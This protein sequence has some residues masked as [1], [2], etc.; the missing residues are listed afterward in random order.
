MS[1]TKQ[2]RKFRLVE[3]K[4]EPKWNKNDDWLETA[5]EP[6]KRERARAIWAKIKDDI[7]L[8]DMLNVQYSNPEMAGSS[9][10]ILMRW[11]LG[12]DKEMPYD[13]LRFLHLAIDKGCRKFVALSRRSLYIKPLRV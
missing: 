8:D 3:E 10:I 5:I 9:V 2:F 6:K 11:I 13:V 1:T 4:D 7:R 12:D